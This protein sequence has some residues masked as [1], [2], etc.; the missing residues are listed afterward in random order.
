MSGVVVALFNLTNNATGTATPIA[1]LMVMYGFNDAMTVTITAILCAL[2]GITAGFIG[3]I[4][5]A[6]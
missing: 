2:C 5:E 6:A 1:G 3:S 4:N